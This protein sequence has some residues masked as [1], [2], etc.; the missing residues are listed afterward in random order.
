MSLS[1]TSHNW[2]MH[3]PCKISEA[4]GGFQGYMRAERGFSAKTISGYNEA[5]RFFVKIVGDLSLETI[6]LQ[7]LIIFK[8]RMTDRNAGLSRISGIIHALKALLTYA[9]DVLDIPVLDIAS[10][11]TPRI[12]RKPVL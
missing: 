1:P 11:K 8:T 9:R 4:L 12:P 5:L 10:I 7:D 6:R 2:T 3:K